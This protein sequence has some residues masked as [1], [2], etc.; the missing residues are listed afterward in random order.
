MNGHKNDLLGT[1][2]HHKVAANLL[3]LIMLLAGAL[4]LERMNV[5]FFPN[6]E[7]EMVSVSV[8]WSGASAEDIEDGI[9]S[10]LEQRLRTL[11]DPR[12]VTST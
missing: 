5:Q 8:T 2:A 7:L 11:D 3:M 9:T 6:F 1:F 4:A 12:Q 10:P